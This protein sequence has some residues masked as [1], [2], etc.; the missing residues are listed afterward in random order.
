MFH[1]SKLLLPRIYFARAPETL[2]LLCQSV[3]DEEKKTFFLNYR[4]IV[5]AAE[6]VSLEGIDADE[7]RGSDYFLFFFL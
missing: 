1:S 7:G 2:S 6:K 5:F 3:S 4:Q